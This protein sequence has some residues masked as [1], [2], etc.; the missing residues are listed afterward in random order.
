VLGDIDGLTFL[1][2]FAGS[3]AIGFEALSRGAA[4]V[5]ALEIDRAAQETIAANVA[6]LHLAAHYKLLK[7]GCSTWSD[8]YPAVT[9]DIVVADPPYDKLQPQSVQKLARH[10]AAEGLLVLSWPMP[11]PA[12][13]FPG[14]TVVADKSYGDARLIFYARRG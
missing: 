12:L 14:L 4:R 7:M 5:T 1:D 8:Q 3:G 11:Q 6:A 13:E 10:V 2:A 9:Y